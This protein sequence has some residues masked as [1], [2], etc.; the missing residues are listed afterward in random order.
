MEELVERFLKYLR[1]ERNSSQHTLV[2]YQNDLKQFLEFC[3]DYFEEEAQS[4]QPVWV[5]RLC[6]RIW[7][8]EMNEMGFKKS[9]LSRKVA[10]VRS[11]FKFCYRK[12][13]INFNPTQLLIYPKQE[14]NLP[15]TASIEDLE[16][17]MD[18]IPKDNPRD[19]QSWAVL[20]LFY[21]S[22]IRLSEL[23]S[24]NVN[25]LT[26]NLTQIQITGKGSKERIV[27]LGQ[28]SKEALKAHLNNREQL[29]GNRTDDDASKAL[30]LALHGQ[31]IYQ[32]AVQRVVKHY[33]SM[34]S[35]ITQKSPHVLRHS[36]A[37]H[38]LNRGAEI[39]VIKELLGHTSLAA[40]QVYT[41][42]SVEYLKRIYD[43]AHPR[44]AEKQ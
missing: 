20:E 15:Q 12:G 29:Y 39:R 18:L 44:A 9:T 35:E 42:T 8:G 3:T 24:L 40:T 10:S 2:S 26:K 34:T 32:R 27:P 11:F 4:I 17:M 25:D 21:S 37:T 23:V 1:I 43:Q 5:D 33:L 30:F 19:I 38:L 31:R 22:G 7:L 14:E 13:E 41:H 28:K 16:K 6:L 36:F